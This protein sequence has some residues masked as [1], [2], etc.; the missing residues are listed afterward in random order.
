MKNFLI[1]STY[2]VGAGELTLSVFF[3]ATHSNSM[4][5]KVMSFL[6]FVTAIWVI[7][8]AATSYVAQTSTTTFYMQLVFSSAIFLITALVHLTI[9]YPHPTRAFDGLHALLLYLPAVIFS[10]IAFTSQ[11]IVVGFTGSA[12]DSGRV[13]PGPL[14]R[15]YNVY[16]LLG[17]V[18]A[19]V[20]L[21]RKMVRSGGDQRK[22]ISIFWWSILIGGLAPIVIDVLIPIFTNGL[23]PNALIGNISTVIWL[24][25]TTYIVLK[26]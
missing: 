15:E 12:I 25:A 10:V 3:W 4:I 20:I 13:I 11:A 1:I 9:I 8:S 16:I 2:L 24:G 7:F 26:K 18:L 14:Y 22:N 6:S 5:R 21:W 23:Y 19:L 17:Y